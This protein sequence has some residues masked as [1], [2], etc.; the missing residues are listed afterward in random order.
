MKFETARVCVLRRAAVQLPL[1]P[2]VE[3]GMENPTLPVEIEPQFEYRCEVVAWPPGAVDGGLLPQV[4]D[5]ITLPGYATPFRVVERV[6]H[7]PAPSTREARLGELQ[8]NLA[9][10]EAESRLL[11]ERPW[12]RPGTADGGDRRWLEAEVVSFETMRSPATDRE[13]MSIGFLVEG[14][15]ILTHRVSTVWQAARLLGSVRGDYSTR[16]TDP[17]DQAEL[18][19]SL[20]PGQHYE[21]E[22]GPHTWKGVERLAIFD[23]RPLREPADDEALA[24]GEI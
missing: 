5:E 9:V 13:Y 3:E 10:E 11:N 14:V 19:A 17:A 22:V 8:V 6:L 7:W 12:G 16:G 1:P 23:A 20:A 24:R 2:W 4:G 15:G 21:V 18:T